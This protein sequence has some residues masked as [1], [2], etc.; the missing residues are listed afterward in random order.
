MYACVWACVCLCMYVYVCMCLYIYVCMR[1][2]VC[3]CVFMCVCVCIYVC[4]YVSH[5]HQTA[6]NDRWWDLDWVVQSSGLHVKSTGTPSKTN[7]KW[8]RKIPSQWTV[9]YIPVDCIFYYPGR[10]WHY[11]HVCYFVTVSK[12]YFEIVVGMWTC[13]YA[14]VFVFMYV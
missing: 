3:V 8:M 12:Y 7:T 10:E 1:V 14:C 2:C 4:V 6:T 11:F 5:V 13:V 9:P